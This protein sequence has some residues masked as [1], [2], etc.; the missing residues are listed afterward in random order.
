MVL[1]AAPSPSGRND[2]K[3]YLNSRGE[4]LDKNG[5]F[6][7]RS[8]KMAHDEMPDGLT[9][10]S[11]AKPSGREHEANE[12]LKKL[13][14]GVE[15]LLEKLDLSDHV[16]RA[17]FDLLRQTEPRSL[18]DVGPNAKDAAKHRRA[19]DEEP[20]RADLQE[21]LRGRGLSEDDLEEVDEIIEQ[22]VS[23]RGEV[24][25]QL[26]V[27]AP[28]GYGGRLSGQ[29]RKVEARPAM[30]TLSTRERSHSPLRTAEF[31]SS[32]ASDGSLESDRPWARIGTGTPGSSQFDPANPPP[33]MSKRVMRQAYDGADGKARAHLED[34]LGFE[35]PEV[36]P[37]PKRR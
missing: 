2:M 18:H 5:A 15:M 19:R 11:T 35:L 3:L 20:D 12:R 9:P 4:L 27:A 25:D 10:A 17:F 32:P 7:G 36:G 14:V 33:L 31:R 24:S 1:Y 8:S 6:W 28:R 26:P 37:W 16:C 22:A 30:G 13:R 21:F 23:E 29:E 34:M